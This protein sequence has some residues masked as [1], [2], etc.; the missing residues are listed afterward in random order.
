[1]KMPFLK[2]RNALISPGVFSV[3]AAAFAI[4][5]VV[6]LLR[7]LAPQLLVTFASPFWRFGTFVGAETHTVAVSFSNATSLGREI[8]TLTQ[9]K[10]LLAIENQTLTA[11]VRDLTVLLGS[12]APAAPRV[13][14]SVLARPPF[15][16]YDTLIIDAGSTAGIHGLCA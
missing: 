13:L 12:R 8:D 3:G 15:T 5:L 6:L 16:D 7:L 14:A 11:Q 9:D 2:R 4:A 10:A 1:M